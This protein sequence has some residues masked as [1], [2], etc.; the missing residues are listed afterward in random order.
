LC[1]TVGFYTDQFFVTYYD[2][3][4]DP[5]LSPLHVLH[6]SLRL[7]GD[8]SLFDSI[9]ALVEYLRK[10]NLFILTV[11]DE[12]EKY[13]LERTASAS[14]YDLSKR[15][16][17]ELYALGTQK[18]SLVILCGSSSKLVDLALK[19]TSTDIGKA[20]ARKYYEY[21]DL[22]HQKFHPLVLPLVELNDV[23]GYIKVVLYTIFF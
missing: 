2:V 3:T 8:Q 16:V 19:R 23:E 4:N 20:L 11:F 9:P 18:G 17:A 12:A 22:N 7:R 15:A 14:D 5:T 10:K 6:A 21:A 13:Y 1:V